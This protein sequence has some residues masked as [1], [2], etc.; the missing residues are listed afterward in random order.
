MKKEAFC[1]GKTYY[2]VLTNSGKVQHDINNDVLKL[3]KDVDS[4]KTEENDLT[5]PAKLGTY[6]IIC[7]KHG[8]KESG[9]KMNLIVEEV[10]TPFLT[11]FE[12]IHAAVMTLGC[13]VIK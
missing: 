1:Y 5:A 11:F 12:K 10:R 8:H 3:D 2:S 6:S 13:A 7:D 4:G 9:M